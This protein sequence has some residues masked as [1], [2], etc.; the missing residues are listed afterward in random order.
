MSGTD[1]FSELFA[2]ESTPLENALLPV[3]PW[4]VMLVD[5]EVDIHAVLRLALQ[6]IHVEGRPLQLLDAKSA[7]EAKTLLTGH[8]DIA[9]ILLDVVMETEQ[10][11]LE[12]VRHIRDERGNKNVQIVLV[13]GQPGYAP[14]RSVITEYDID[15]YRLKSEL[16]ADRIYVTV[17]AALRTFQAEVKLANSEQQLRLVLEGAEL[18]FWDWDIVTGK[19]ERNERW[20]AILGYSHEEIQQ[21][22]QQWTDFIYPADRERAWQSIND[23]L[24][25]RLAQHRLEYRMLHKDGSIRWILDQANITLRDCN[26][27]PVRMG[28]T[29]IDV[30]ARKQ[31]EIE[32]KT[33]IDTT[34]DGFWTVSVL[35]GRFLEVNQA[36]C[37]MIGYSRE[38]LL[39]M[40][41]SDI[42]ANELLDETRK[43][44]RSIIEG[45][46]ERFE[47]QHRHKSGEII[48]VEISAK[49]LDVY[50]GLIVVF[51]RDITNRKRSEEA[52]KLASLV[53]QA[54]SEAMVIVNA[55]NQILAV[56]P[57][58]NLI[59]GYT[60]DEVLGK[61]PKILSSGL[62]DAAFY[63]AMWQTISET[64]TWKGE[65]WSRRKN[66]DVYAEL[67]TIN[68]VYDDHGAVLRRVA[69]FSDITKKKQ[70]EEI[71]WQ[72]ANFDV[73]TGLPNR[74]MS[75]ARLDLE[76][77]KASRDEH[78]LAILF[79]DLDHFKAVNDTLGHEMGDML[80]KEVARRMHDCVRES[81]TVGRLG[82]DEFIVILGDLDDIARVGRIANNILEKLIAPFR[83]G[84]ELMTISAS[85][86]ITIFPDD[87]KDAAV[88]LKNADQAMYAAKR[89][90]R[91]RFQ[92]YMPELQEVAKMR[93]R[94][95]NDMH[96]ALANNEFKVYYQP[97]VDLAS[98]SICKAEAL[99][100]WQHLNQGL[101]SPASFIP[102][103]EET[104]QII[105]IGHWIFQQA[106]AF[107]ADLRKKYHPE[108]QISINKSPVQ[109]RATAGAPASWW[110]YLMEQGYS[111]Q[112]VVLEITEDL[113]MEARE[114]ICNRL[115]DLRQKGIQVA[116]DDFGT[117]YSSLSCLQKLD[118]DYIKIDQSFIRNLTADSSDF[119]LCEAMIVMAHTLGIKVIAEGIENR[120]QHD[121]LTQIG[122]DY[123]QGY[124]WSKP[125][126][127][128]AFE[129]LLQAS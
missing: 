15:G 37:D 77:K 110:H 23:V 2:P 106:A 88:L 54:S 90:G 63:Q 28:G 61:D 60:S 83:L 50:G 95:A 84:G 6:D 126:P 112:S 56:N 109:F 85:I 49:F 4:K 100:R 21:T 58:F 81:D 51:L 86:G 31:S 120:E 5:D 87:A 38:E 123:G 105:E 57:A 52:L 104:G 36:Y 29:H 107:S 75:Y 44:I 55:E 67:L 127:A 91:N 115:L 64:G 108:F 94:L 26:G 80:L 103:A 79:I 113:L 76:L 7:E 9:L 14:Q 69:L 111:T 8:P 66:G 1:N 68:T 99:I 72:Q 114:D 40:S 125:V 62:H 39:N 27:K 96:S 121:L 74:I 30:T 65:I 89:Q 12:L 34:H 33:F 17:Y 41:I 22:T 70:H 93:L 3:E 46:E 24:E 116:L 32:F 45:Y 25:G 78:K 98:G 122:C 129:K 47:T 35:D 124:F 71:I 43:H 82:G 73:L 48:D 11:G 59:T 53:Y 18:G 117:G 42:E 16:T 119:A 128:E 102:V 118:I 10:A 101:I 13:T 20:A 92:Y 97:I 19:V